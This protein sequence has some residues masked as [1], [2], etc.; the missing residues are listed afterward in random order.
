MKTMK[1][2]EQTEGIEYPVRKGVY[3]VIF[4]EQKDKLAIVQLTRGPSFPARRRPGRKRIPRR[5]PET[6]NA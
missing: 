5:M 4:N 2:G 1:F 3:A 6:R